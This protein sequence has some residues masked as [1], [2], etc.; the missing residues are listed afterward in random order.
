MSA[1]GRDDDAPAPAST[2]APA[3]EPGISGRDLL[4]LAKPR[5]TALVVFTTASGLWFAPHAS[6]SRARIALTMIATVVVVAAANALNMYLE[7][8]TDA[9]MSRTKSRPLP[10]GRMEPKVAL[11]FGLVLSAISPSRC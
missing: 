7:R 9:L 4:Q 8:D 10:A 2:P 3:V 11:W 1:A 6:L 5:I